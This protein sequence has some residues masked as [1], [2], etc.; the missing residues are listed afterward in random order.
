MAL[1]KQNINT[2]T[3]T[4]YLYNIDM[5]N[6]KLKIHGNQFNE[7]E[8]QTDQMSFEYLFEGTSEGSL[9]KKKR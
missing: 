1:Y 5:T 8:L 3:N 2:K 6:F 9:A 7:T 4:I